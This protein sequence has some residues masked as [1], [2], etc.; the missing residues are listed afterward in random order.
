MFVS[1]QNSYVENLT[2][3][4]MGLRGGAFGL[5][6]DLIN[7]VSAFIKEATMCRYNKKSATSKVL[8]KA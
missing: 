1:L 4:V 8:I 5:W 6:L 3:K 7:G 2:P